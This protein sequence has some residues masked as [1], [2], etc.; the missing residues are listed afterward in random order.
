M[1][2]L[3]EVGYWQMGPAETLEGGTGRGGGEHGKIRGWK[4]KNEVVGR[5]QRGNQHT[6]EA[7]AIGQETHPH[8]ERFHLF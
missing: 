5:R 7:I 8:C 6:H 3:P 4:T 1:G 2:V